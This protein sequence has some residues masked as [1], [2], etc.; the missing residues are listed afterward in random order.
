MGLVAFSIIGIGF[1][2]GS[3]LTSA[4]RRLAQITPTG[5]IPTTPTPT[6]TSTPCYVTTGGSLVGLR[7]PCTPTPT[8]TFT[9][10]ATST[11][12]PTAT[13]CPAA[14][15]SGGAR[16]G[17]TPTATVSAGA[18]VTS[19]PEKTAT[20]STSR[21]P[22]TNAE[23]PQVALRVENQPAATG[24]GSEF[25]FQVKAL[26]SNGNL[27]TDYTARL[28]LTAKL[29]G[30]SSRS[31]TLATDLPVTAG[32]GLF[33]QRFSAPIT[34]GTWNFTLQDQEYPEINAQFSISMTPGG[35]DAT[36]MKLSIAPRRIQVGGGRKAL[37]NSVVVDRFGNPI[38]GVEVSFQEETGALALAPRRAISNRDGRVETVVQ[39]PSS[40]SS[41]RVRIVLPD[42]TVTGYSDTLQFF[43]PNAI[44]EALQAVD[45]VAEPLRENAQVQK[46]VTG[47]QVVSKTAA[48]VSL[49]SVVISF[50]TSLPLGGQAALTLLLGLVGVGSTSRRK[51]YSIVYNS[52]NKRPIEGATVRIF[53]TAHRLVQ[54][55]VSDMW[56]RVRILLPHGR[57]FFD[58]QKEN[59]RYPSAVI[60]SRVDGRFS[61]IYSG[62]AYLVRT[63]HPSV[64]SLSIPMDPLI[65]NAETARRKGMW[66]HAL[67][68][69]IETTGVQFEVPLLA[70][71][72]VLSMF[73]LM[74][75]PVPLN[76]FFVIM[77]PL[78]YLLRS[79]VRDSISNTHGS[80]RDTH[81]HPQEGVVVQLFSEKDHRLVETQ[82][83]DPQGRFSF[84]VP[85]GEYRLRILKDGYQLA[86][87]RTH[88]P[89]SQRPYAGGVIRVTGT[90]DQYLRANVFI[91]R[92]L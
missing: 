69:W 30:V 87:D 73:A 45:D 37:V 11:S 44:D 28:T 49:T 6:P 40:P 68:T 34:A 58:F 60:S 24:V 43:E 59:F 50:G 85:P 9:P 19:T 46:V 31:T 27:A 25:G 54:T 92:M 14:G 91:E 61:E 35:P 71:G 47:S 62:G 79:L 5:P 26:K 41:S 29:E 66:W 64:L 57:Y 52:L 2:F 77:Y 12:T 90:R 84:L 32:T 7:T 1:A 10:T 48:A 67:H 75:R 20:P 80:V 8:P 51:N 78:I 42:K 83:T 76:G 36:Q 39:T 22:G 15:C 74:V 53:D 89:R 86:S 65:L 55:K 38:S 72:F 3:Y 4:D 88:F 18:Q 81:N 23:A 56:G 21:N 63:E 17:E 13:P 70:L 82:E 16:T 33:P